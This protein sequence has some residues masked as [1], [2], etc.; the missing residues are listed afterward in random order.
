MTENRRGLIV[1]SMLTTARM[2][3]PGGWG[4]GRGSDTAMVGIQGAL[5]E[6]RGS[7]GGLRTAGCC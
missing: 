4:R 2:A 5:S 6:V 7:D 1:E 3:L